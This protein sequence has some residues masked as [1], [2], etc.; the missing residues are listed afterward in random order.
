[1]KRQEKKKKTKNSWTQ[2]TV[3]WL[4]GEGVGAVKGK[5]GQIYGYREDDL[6]QSGRDTMQYT[7]DVLQKYTL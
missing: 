7:D 6:I 2:T 4:P 3:Q 5:G 1:M